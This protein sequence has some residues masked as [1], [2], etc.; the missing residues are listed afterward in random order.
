MSSA[1]LSLRRHTTSSRQS[2]YKSATRH[3]VLLL[4][5]FEETLGANPCVPEVAGSKSKFCRNPSAVPDVFQSPIVAP[6]SS[7]R[8]GSASHQMPKFWNML[9]GLAWIAAPLLML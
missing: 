3:G 2:P 1:L 9:L 8:I 5:L 6:S 7:S 4:P